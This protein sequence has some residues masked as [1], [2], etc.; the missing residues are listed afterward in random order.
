MCPG[1]DIAMAMVE[2]APNQPASHSL[3]ALAEEAARTSLIAGYEPNEPD[4]EPPVTRSVSHGLRAVSWKLES[5][6]VS[7]P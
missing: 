7:I 5:P 1:C 2:T 3:T 6:E 4:D